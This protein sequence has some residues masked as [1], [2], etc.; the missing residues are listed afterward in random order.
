MSLN[1]ITTIGRIGKDAGLFGGGAT[2]VLSF[3]VAS[4][5]G[6]GERKVTL[7]YKVSIFVSEKQLDRAEKLKGMLVKG[8]E[9][10]IPGDLGEE[11]YN[12]K[13]SLTISCS[14]NDV[15]IT[16]FKNPKPSAEGASDDAPAGDDGIPF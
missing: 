12:D 7:W 14:L 9:V 15:Q 10:C 4:D 16:K 11:T 8:T 1:K 13:K 3:S 2:K 6:Y 5:S